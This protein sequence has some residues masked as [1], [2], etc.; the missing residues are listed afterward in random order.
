MCARQPVF[1]INLNNDINHSERV[2]V[3]WLREGRVRPFH[4]YSLPFDK[5]GICRLLIRSLLPPRLFQI[6]SVRF[7]L[8]GC[9]LPHL[10]VALLL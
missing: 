10:L 1:S 6:S 9:R 7:V 3:I 8:G 5:V 2:R 4:R